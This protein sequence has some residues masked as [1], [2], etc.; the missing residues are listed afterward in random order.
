MPARKRT[1]VIAN[2]RDDV[3]AKRPKLCGRMGA[4]S[5]DSGADSELRS[6]CVELIVADACD[7]AR[8]RV[9]L[10][11]WDTVFWRMDHGT[12]AGLPRRRSLVMLP[13]S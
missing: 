1:T 3:S 5:L 9:S 2:M 8:N 4:T 7:F 6:V 10:S 11:F 13:I 12:F